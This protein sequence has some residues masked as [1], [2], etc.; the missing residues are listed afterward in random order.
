MA[1]GQSARAAR[2]HLRP[3]WSNNL[4]RYTTADA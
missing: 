1:I 2:L 4:D 3:V